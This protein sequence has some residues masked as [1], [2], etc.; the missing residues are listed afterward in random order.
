MNSSLDQILDGYTDDQID[1]VVDFLRRCAQ[2][3]QSAT[4]QLA[5]DPG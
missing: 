5:A 4:D 2:A 3:G 1:L